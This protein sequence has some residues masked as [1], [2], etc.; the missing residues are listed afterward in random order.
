MKAKKALAVLLVAVMLLATLSFGASAA[1]EAIVSGPI[2]TAYTDCEYFNPQGLV[3][4]I[5]GKEIPYSPIDDNFKFVPGLNEKL[6]VGTSVDVYYKVVIDVDKTAE[7]KVGSIPV[8]VSHVWGE[9]TY[10]DNNYHG[11]RCL[12]CAIIDETTFTAHNV[13]EYIP[14]DD[15]GLFI[16][17]TKTG[18]CEDCHEKITVNIEGSHKFESIF[19]GNLT[20]TEELIKYIID[21]V[22]VSLVQMLVGIK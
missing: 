4:T 14:N 7:I 22:L 16:E 19:T 12:G 10:L 15:G 11:K 17:Q 8:E 2:K 13:K 18:V 3:I 5:D 20:K 1:D 9:Y 6:T 21:V